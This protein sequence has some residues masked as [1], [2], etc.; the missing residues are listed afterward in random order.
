MEKFGKLKGY[1]VQLS[2][3]TLPQKNIKG[4]NVI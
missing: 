2:K 1:F 4:E 3:V